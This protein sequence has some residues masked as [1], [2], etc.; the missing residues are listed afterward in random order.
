MRKEKFY[1]Q[2]KIMLFRASNA[3]RDFFVNTCYLFL[4]LI[5]HAFIHTDR[6]NQS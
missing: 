1:L 2:Q 5:A 3:Q 4:I 6:K